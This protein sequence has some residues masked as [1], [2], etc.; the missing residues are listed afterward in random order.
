MNLKNAT[1]FSIIGISYIFI[2]RTVATFFPDIFT[3]LVVTR[4]NTLLSLLASL[5]I[6]VFYIY[7]YKD[8]VSEKQIA[9]KNASLFAIIGSIA[10]LLL[11]LKGIPVVFNL[12]VFRS[13]VFNIIAPWIGS[14]F[15]LYFFIIFY[16]ETIHNLQSK[17]K[18]AILL[19]VIGSSLSTLIRTFILFNYFYSG[20]F[21]WFWDYSIKFPLIVIPISV[22][23]FFTSFYFFLTFY[24]EQ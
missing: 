14:I 1:L 5:A 9:L 3:N 22:F 23:M 17:L 15:S 8:Y 12:Y 2:S 7:F 6:V 20:K 19:A 4:I 18:L 13:Q 21:K 10:V 16:K 24:K 11:F